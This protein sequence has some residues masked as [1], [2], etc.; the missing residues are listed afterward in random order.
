MLLKQDYRVKEI[1]AEETHL[2]RHPVLRTGKPVNTCIFNGDDLPSTIHLG[3]FNNNNLVGVVSFMQ[4]KH[5]AFI[6]TPQYQLR[7]MAILKTYQGKGLGNILLEYGETLL[8]QKNIDLI[9]CNARKIAV[10]FY[11]RRGY[12]IKGTS[13]NISDI[14]EHFMMYKVLVEH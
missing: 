12:K 7:G 13:L 3:L 10:N 5:E 4:V 2:V 11:K 8:K 9:W 14:G 6:E 1:L